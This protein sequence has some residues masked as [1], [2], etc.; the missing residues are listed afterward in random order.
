MRLHQSIGVKEKEL[1]ELEGV[2]EELRGKVRSVERSEVLSQE[3]A[4][5]VIR[6]LE[7]KCVGLNGRVEVLEG[8]KVGRGQVELSH[9]D[10]HVQEL[11]KALDLSRN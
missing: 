4:E 3:R 9:A 2:N 7:E 5:E 11:A 6:R 10:I 8:E 1:V